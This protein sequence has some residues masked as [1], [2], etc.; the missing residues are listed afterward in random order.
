MPLSYSVFTTRR[1]GVLPNIPAG[2]DDLKWVPSTS[3]LIHDPTTHDAILI[4][5]PLT[6]SMTRDLLSWL[7]QSGKNLKSVYITHPHGDHYFGLGAILK[8]YPEA[9]GLATAQAV[10][11]MWAEIGREKDGKGFWHPRFGDEI[12]DELVLPQV[13]EGDVIELG[14]E[15]L[16]VIRTGHTDTDETSCVW[17]PSIGL[18]VTGDAVYN[19]VYPYLSESGSKEARDEWRRALDRIEALRPKTVVGGHMDPE[20]GHGPEAISK[21]REYLNAIERVEGETTSVD[22]FYQNMLELFPRRINPGSLLGGV[23]TLKNNK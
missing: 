8:Q 15:R 10:E 5:T 16:E 3:T 13:L 7:A 17:V 14:G 19:G 11:K 20:K 12:A 2:L 1:P 6:T 23:N 9:K 21:T 18:A 4:D 22:E